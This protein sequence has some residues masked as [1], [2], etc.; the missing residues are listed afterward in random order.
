MLPSEFVY[1]DLKPGDCVMFATEPAAHQHMWRL[2]TV[3]VLKN[4]SCD[5]SII[6]AVGAEYRSDCWHADDPRC[7]TQPQMY[8]MAGRG[9]FRLAPKEITERKLYQETI[10]KL[11]ANY[12]RLAEKIDALDKQVEALT[13]SLTAPAG[14]RRGE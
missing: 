3:Q 5:I 1:P 11:M 9:V 7:L 6:T 4:I 8:R 12:N 14:K 2:G 10:P 13:A